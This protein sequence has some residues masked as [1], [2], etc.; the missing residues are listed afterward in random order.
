MKISPNFEIAE[1]FNIIMDKNVLYHHTRFDTLKLILTPDGISFRGSYYD[2]FDNNDYQW[3]KREVAPIIKELC[4]SSGEPYDSDSSFRPII[5]SFGQEPCSDYMWTHYADDYSGVQIVL[6]YA[7]IKKYALSK[8]DYLH[9]CVYMKDKVD[10]ADFLANFTNLEVESVN[11]MQMNYE[12]ISCLIKRPEFDKEKETRYIH[13]YPYLFS[14]DYADYLAGKE[15][16]FKEVSSEYDKK[17]HFINLPKS[18]LLGMT[19]GY[20]ST[21]RLKEVEEHLASC[22][23]NVSKIKIQVYKPSGL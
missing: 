21:D 10:M 16:S 11:H 6:D 15:D 2:K 22:G 14:I 8:L 20:K 4:E 3:T 1:I 5:I 17:E 23:F 13:S 9:E 19:V 12:A 18:A 7:E